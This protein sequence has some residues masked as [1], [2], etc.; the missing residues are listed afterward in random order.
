MTH[1]A[2]R[3]AAAGPLGELFPPEVESAVAAAT[4]TLARLQER[5]PP[6]IELSIAAQASIYHAYPYLF[7]GA[8]PGL[9]GATVGDLGLAARLFAD[10]LF[11]ADDLMDG[12]PTDRD[13]TTNLV[14][15]QAM[16]FEGYRVLHRLFAPGTRFWDRFQDY[17]ALYAHACIEERRFVDSAADLSELTQPAALRIAKGKSS[18]AKFVVAGLAELAADEAPVEALTRGLDRYYVARQMVDDLSD[19]R[20]DLERGYPSLLLARVAAGDLAGLSRKELAARSDDVGRAIYQGGHARYVVKL[21]LQALREADELSEA[22]PP[23]LWDRVRARLGERCRALLGELDRIASM[24]P[25][26]SDARPRRLELTLPA[27]ADPWQEAAWS[28]LRFL[29]RRWP[30]RAAGGGAA[31]GGEGGRRLPRTGGGLLTRA[32]VA[33]ALCD[34]DDALGGKLRPWIEEQARYL[35]EHRPRSGWGWST[36]CP[37]LP[38]DGA[39]LARLLRLLVRLGRRA[40]IEAQ[41]EP[42]LALLL[43]RQAADGALPTWIHEDLAPPGGGPDEAV[44]A[45]LLRALDL[46]DRERFR[47]VVERG[48]AWIEAHQQGDGSWTSPGVHGP[49][50]PT[51]SCLELL[52]AVRPGSRAIARGVEFLRR[53]RREDGGWGPEPGRTD[54]LSSALALLGLARARAADGEDGRRARAGASA[55]LAAADFDAAPPEGG[56]VLTAAFALQASL[57]WHAI[58]SCATE[59]APVA[60]EALA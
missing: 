7:L 13:S 55:L 19:W 56:G 59:P 32:L 15:I 52:A 11:V 9:G 60:V 10:S 1:S 36:V 18:L 48:G 26:A 46:Y 22:M 34:A 8:F 5:W 25:R 21:A 30:P 41:C 50:L 37:G 35:V 54:A 47:P 2:G 42:L 45:D 53:T 12:D 31:P 20:Q 27:P 40:E 49:F 39:H 29:V 14:R 28:A 4:A 17:L 38:P 24:P 33:D 44:T 23:C 57:A 58:E 51:A 43:P 16:Q 6:P 3:I